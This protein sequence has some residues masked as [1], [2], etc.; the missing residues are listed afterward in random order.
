[1][2]YAA[3]TL[4]YRLKQIDLDGTAS[5]TDPISIERAACEL[6]L[7]QPVPNPTREKAIVRFAVPDRQEI[8]L[9]LCD[10]MGNYVLITE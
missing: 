9:H 7:R 3:D 8:T 6:V 2:S 5:L 1:M 4:E 10:T